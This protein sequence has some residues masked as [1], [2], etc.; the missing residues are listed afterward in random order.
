MCSLAETLEV[1]SCFV[2]WDSRI[3]VIFERLTC[4]LDEDYS[5]TSPCLA[6]LVLFRVTYTGFFLPSTV[7]VLLECPVVVIPPPDYP[8]TDPNLDEGPAEPFYGPAVD[9]P[10]IRPPVA[11]WAPEP[12]ALVLCWD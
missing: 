5:P 6:D 3:L 2:E 10:D 1:A 11:V 4:E 8:I 12:P 7:F 9:A